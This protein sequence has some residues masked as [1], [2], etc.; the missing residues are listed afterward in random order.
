MPD[1][2]PKR[3]RNTNSPLGPGEAFDRIADLRDSR[4]AR[5][6]AIIAAFDA[7]EAAKELAIAERVPAASQ[8]RLAIML[9]AYPEAQQMA[10]DAVANRQ[11]P[12]PDAFP[13]EL[14]AGARPLEPGRAERIGRMT[15]GSR[16]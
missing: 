6:N 9:R 7:E 2:M 3:T 10:A 11:E 4:E 14:P 8:D 12:E 13:D 16:K 15:G 5:R 1:E